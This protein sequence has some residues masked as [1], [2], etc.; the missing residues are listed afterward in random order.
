MTPTPNPIARLETG[1]PGLDALLEGGFVRGSVYIVEGPPGAGKTMLANQICFH[2][3]RQK[4]RALYVT[5]LAETHERMQKHLQRMAFYDASLV[6][7][8]VYFISAFRALQQDGLPALQRLLRESIMERNVTV[9]VIDGMVTAEEVSLT[10]TPGANALTQDAGSSQQFKQF[11]H[12]LQ[13]VCSMTGCTVLLLSSTERPR[14]FHPAYTMV[15]GILELTNELS[16]LN[17]IRQIHVRKMRGT[18]QLLGKHHFEIRHSGVVVHPRIETQL[19]DPP[20]ETVGL[21]SEDERVPFGIATLD[22]MLGGGLPGKSITM[23]VGP[24]G[25]GKTLLSSQF[26]AEG[27]RRG[28]PGLYFGFYERPSALMAKGRR[29]GM[30]LETYALDGLLEIIWQRPVEAVIDELVDRLL[31]A[32]RRLGAKRLVIDGM[33]GF[34]LALDDYP[35]RVR[36]VF[37]AIADE[38]ERLGV[39]AIYTVETREVFGPTIEVPVHGVSAATQNIILLR[40]VEQRSALRLLLSV[41]KVRDSAFDR[42]VRQLR[43]TEQGLVVDDAFG[44]DEQVLSASSLYPSS[45]RSARK[46]ARAAHSGKR[47]THKPT[48]KVGKRKR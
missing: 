12:E 11:I 45:A 26:L 1:V 4:E 37:A 3:A 48:R 17:T 10:R 5:L 14:A 19:R 42:T 15:D 9:L 28:E 47:A 18:D 32:V 36:G 35:D 46:P 7:E 33:Q 22:A 2:G 8:A 41:L 29:L 40:H 43:I 27:A 13:T 34:Q 16:G 20:P 31:T 24:T 25:T 39:T 6:P 23:I 44:L 30:D 38:L 21:D